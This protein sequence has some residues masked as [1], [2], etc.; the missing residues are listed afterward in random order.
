MGLYCDVE[1]HSSDGRIDLFLLT[2]DELYLIELKMNKAVAEAMHQIDL[3]DYAARFALSG[4]P[5]IKV[6][7]IFDSEQ[8]TIS[9]WT[10][11]HSV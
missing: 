3:K 9:E 2:K 8:R 6:G 1:V 7:I 11:S 4:F 5:V 10:I